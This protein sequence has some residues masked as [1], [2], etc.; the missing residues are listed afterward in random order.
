MAKR[1]REQLAKLG[2]KSWIDPYG[3]PLLELVEQE[4]EQRAQL[5]K[6]P[7]GDRRVAGAGEGHWEG[8]GLEAQDGAEDLGPDGQLKRGS[9]M[10]VFPECR[11]YEEV[12]AAL[13]ALP[14][15]WYPALLAAI[16]EAS[17]AKGVWAPGGAAL[18][19]EKVERRC[20]PADSPG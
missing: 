13:R 14:R 17:A 18:L 4:S 16:V 2:P 15:T 8:G 6:V 19:V 3:V 7:E 1:A 5:A 12:E 9:G 20:P 10:V 11:S